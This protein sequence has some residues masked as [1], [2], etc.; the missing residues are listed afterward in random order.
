MVQPLDYN[1]FSRKKKDANAD[2]GII[3]WDFFYKE[4]FFFYPYS[5]IFYECKDLQSRGILKWHGNAT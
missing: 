3:D 2:L 1:I 4:L 5:G